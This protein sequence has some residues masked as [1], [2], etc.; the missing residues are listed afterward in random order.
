MHIAS[1]QMGHYTELTDKE[2]ILITSELAK[3]KNNAKV[4]TKL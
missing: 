2:K 4:I 1:F 3:A